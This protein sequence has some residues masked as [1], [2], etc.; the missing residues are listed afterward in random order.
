MAAEWSIES[1]QIKMVM[2]RFL[3]VGG[4]R[5]KQKTQ[6]TLETLQQYKQVGE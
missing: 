1:C 5:T 6:Y 2:M 3:P 4:N